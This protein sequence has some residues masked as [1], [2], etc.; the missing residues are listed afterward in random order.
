TAMGL[1]DRVTLLGA[2]PARAT[3]AKGR[4]AVVPSLAE[5][6]PYVVIEAAA[7]HLP[8]IATNVGGIKEIFGPTAPSLVPANDAAA[9]GAAMQAFLDNPQAAE[10]EMRVRLAHVQA[11]FSI[12]RM[13][14]SIAA[15][16]HGSTGNVPGQLH[17]L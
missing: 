17:R 10:A 1:E 4:C 16:Y 14:R 13:T 5:S 8:V 11:G 6:L 15:L 9:L 7:A 3:F 12:A 2:Q